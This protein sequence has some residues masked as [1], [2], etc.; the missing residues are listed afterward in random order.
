MIAIDGRPDT[1]EERIV[2][3]SLVGTWGLWAIG[4][5]YIAIPAMGW[6]LAALVVADRLG[7]IGA[8]EEEALPI[9]LGAWIWIGGMALTGVALVI[10]HLELGLFQFLKSFMGWM[11]GWALIAVFVFVGAATRIRAQVLFRASNMLALQTLVIAPVMLVAGAL[12]LPRLEFVSPLAV[13]GGSGP[14][15][16]TFQLYGLDVGKVRWTFYSPWSPAAGLVACISLVLA[17]YDRNPMRRAI[18]IAA[19][20]VVCAMAHSRLAYIVVPLVSVLLLGLSNLTRPAVYAAAGAAVLVMLPLTDPLL[21]L[22]ADLQDD[23]QNARADSSRVRAWLQSIALHRW[24]NEAPIWGHGVVERGPH[25]VAFMM[26]GTH[27]TWNG[28]LFVKGAVGFAA[29]AVPMAWS[30]IET[31]AKAQSDRVARAALGVL[32]VLFCFSFG[33]NMETLIYLYWPGMVLVGIAARRRFVNPYQ[34]LLGA[35]P[36]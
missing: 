33:E 5:L 13:L 30:M 26:I 34:P 15:Y 27:H 20:L 32:L 14:E 3:W 10:G 29:L 2:Y 31:L 8:W 4:A 11:K 28:L 17:F 9:P 23:F 19:T 21:E 16:F 6:S 1:L 7:I 22:I 35:A 25:L 24:W 12:Q 36:A 18:G